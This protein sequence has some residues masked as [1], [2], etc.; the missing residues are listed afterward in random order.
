MSSLINLSTSLLFSGI[1]PWLRRNES[2]QEV[3]ENESSRKPVVVREGSVLKQLSGQFGLNGDQI[4]S[5]V[6]TMVP[7]LA[8]GLKDKLAAG[9]ADT[10][11]KLISGGSLTNFLD[12]PASLASPAATET[13]NNL[14]S[15]VFGSSGIN[16]LVSSLSE[17][18]GI[19]SGIMT[20]MLP[21]VM[22][23]LGGFLAKGSAT[24]GGDLTSTLGALT[25][26][27]SGLLGAVKSLAAKFLG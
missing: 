22:T 12:T 7:A 24:S 2:L 4:T 10:L 17:K 23:M 18:S 21:V 8:G 11:S 6:S 19:S 16:T 3:D 25:G 5:A 20:K 13:G 27:T 26:D 14:L 15:Q 1:V 9:G